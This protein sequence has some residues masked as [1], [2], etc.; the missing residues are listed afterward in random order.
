M[1]QMFRRVDTV[2]VQVADVD[3]ATAWYAEVLG[4]TERFR[5]QDLACLGAGETSITLLGPGWWKN[6]RPGRTP[7]AFNF[8]VP[9]AEQ[10]HRH[11][12]DQ[13]VTCGPVE[14]DGTSSWFWFDD[15]DGNRLEVCSFPER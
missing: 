4:L 13:G 5:R 6:G 8:Y 11:L 9:D 10:A 1:G 15:P 12:R 2:F 14:M 3:K 7:A